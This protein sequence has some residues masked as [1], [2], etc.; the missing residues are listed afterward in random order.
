MRT[1]QLDI[2]LTE[3]Y[4]R[5]FPFNLLVSWKEKTIWKELQLLNIC[6]TFHLEMLVFP[7]EISV[8][9]ISVNLHTS[10]IWVSLPSGTR[11]NYLKIEILSWS[12]EWLSRQ[13]LPH[14][15]FTEKK[16]ELCLISFILNLILSTAVDT[17]LFLS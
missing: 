16:N 4:L 2:I 3:M 14:I 6:G 15:L 17:Y 9:I 7:N 10:C 11:A 1:S 13:L 12:R 8:I 5:H